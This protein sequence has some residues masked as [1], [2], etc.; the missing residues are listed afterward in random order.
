MDLVS[1]LMPSSLTNR[2]YVDKT[3]DRNGVWERGSFTTPL[4][5]SEDRVQGS[6]GKYMVRVGNHLE[7]QGF[8]VL[9]M[10][11]PTRVTNEPVDED[12]KKYVMY[13]WCRRRPIGI[14]MDIPDNQVAAML[15]LGMKLK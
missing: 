14:N 3:L 10:T 7:L 2:S 15:D 11:K 9:Y 4:S 1:R 6:A 5:V 13:A 12:R 8:T